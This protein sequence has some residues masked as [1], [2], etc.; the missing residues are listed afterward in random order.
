MVTTIPECS[1]S[2]WQVQFSGLQA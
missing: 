1:Y 2:S